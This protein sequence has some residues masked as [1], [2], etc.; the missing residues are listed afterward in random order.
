MSIDALVQGAAPVASARSS[1]TSAS[2]TAGLVCGRAAN[3]AGS[4]SGASS[5]S[6]RTSI[7]DTTSVMLLAFEDFSNNSTLGHILSTGHLHWKRKKNVAW[8]NVS[9]QTL[10]P[11]SRSLRIRPLTKTSLSNSLTNKFALSSY[12]WLSPEDFISTKDR[13]SWSLRPADSVHFT[14][15]SVPSLS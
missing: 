11:Y 14:M 1:A 7:A 10:Q 9:T 12:P 8:E 5:R 15:R 2:H 3:A 13:M 6:T 4:P